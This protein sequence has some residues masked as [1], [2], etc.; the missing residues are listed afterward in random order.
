MQ[1]TSQYKTLEEKNQYNT[2]DDGSLTKYIWILSNYY[3][4]YAVLLVLLQVRPSHPS[5]WYHLRFPGLP[6]IWWPA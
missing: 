2:H 4:L 3:L 1:L 6:D 5:G